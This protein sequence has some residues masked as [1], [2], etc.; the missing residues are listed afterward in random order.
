MFTRR[1]L[2]ITAVTAALVLSAACRGKH[3]RT[4]VE[5]EEPA[6]AEAPPRLASTLKMSDPAATGQLLKGVYGLEGGGAW[7]WTAGHF[8]IALRPPLSAAQRGATLSLAFTVPE[9]VI[10][11]LGKITLSASIGATKL[12]SEPCPKSGAYTFTADVPAELLTKDSVTVDFDLD[13]SLPATPAD[14][15]EL[16][17][18]VTSAGLESK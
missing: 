10:Q 6:A 7:R 17:V 14:Q 1:R 18:I 12:K 8:S 16:G 3:H 15:R 5:N 9:V 11:K 2:V 4:T 13:K